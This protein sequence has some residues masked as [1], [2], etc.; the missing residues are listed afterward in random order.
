MLES[1][2]VLCSAGIWVWHK[3]LVSALFGA[4]W[5]G[6]HGLVCGV[7]REVAAGKDPALGQR[8]GFDHHL[9]SSIRLLSRITAKCHHF[10]R[11]T[12]CIRINPLSEGGTTSCKA[13]MGLPFGVGIMMVVR[14]LQGRA[15]WWERRVGGEG[16]V[17]PFSCQPLLLHSH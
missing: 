1:F 7:G 10:S 6:L 8:V 9:A 14:H 2:R 3:K 11:K 12:F 16:R 4:L 5:S 17:Q 15:A 13:N